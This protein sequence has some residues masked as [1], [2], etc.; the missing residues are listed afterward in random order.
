MNA[1]TEYR[2]MPEL[3]DHQLSKLYN[4]WNTPKRDYYETL[5][6][7]L[8]VSMANL[9]GFVP[10]LDMIQ[11]QYDVV[12][13]DIIGPSAAVDSYNLFDTWPGEIQIGLAKSPLADPESDNFTERRLVEYMAAYY[14]FRAYRWA[15]AFTY[16][17]C[18]TFGEHGGRPPNP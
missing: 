2:Y 5:F 1:S 11:E 8:G 4:K 10:T 12:F 13:Q 17:K 6:V 7:S 15:L 14:T 18:I 3:N 16:Y 9:P